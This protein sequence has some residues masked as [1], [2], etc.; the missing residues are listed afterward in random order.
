MHAQ[1]SLHAGQ[2]SWDIPGAPAL[3]RHG[4]ARS[5]PFVVLVDVYICIIKFLQQPNLCYNKKSGLQC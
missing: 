1:G 3:T 4:P 5:T 2:C